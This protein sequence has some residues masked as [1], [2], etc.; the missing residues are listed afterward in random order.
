MSLQA[1]EYKY[2]DSNWTNLKIDLNNK[3]SYF[4]D[5]VS[6]IKECSNELLHSC[7]VINNTYFAIPKSVINGD[8]SYTRISITK[9]IMLIFWD[10]QLGANILGQMQYGYTIQIQDIKNKTVNNI[11][12]YNEK[13]GVIMFHNYNGSYIS[14]TKYGLFNSKRK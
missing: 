1:H 2:I 5:T 4:S 14:T 6:N 9:D 12:I 8:Y 7:F 11:L 3:R 10:K 13:Q